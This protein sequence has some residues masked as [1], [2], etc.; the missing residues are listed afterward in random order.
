MSNSF[1]V[2]TRAAEELASLLRSRQAAP[3]L[4]LRLSVS[5]GG[6]AGMNYV[7]EITT[8]APED[9]AV[10]L[11]GANI[12]LDPA[13][14]PFLD[15]AQLD[16]VDDLSDSGFRVVNPNAA[17]S[18]GC[19]TSFEPAQRPADLPAY[20]PATDGTACAPGDLSQDTPTPPASGATGTS[21]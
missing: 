20:D 16:Y 4:G 15:G 2:T 12:F 10:A 6:C 9:V 14:Q 1:S 21:A 13:S 5:R 18:C 8:Q 7:M 17:R 11:A 3:D 19:G